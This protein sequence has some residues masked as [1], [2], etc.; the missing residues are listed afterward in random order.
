MR[1][2]REAIASHN[3]VQSAPFA[4]S[5][6]LVPQPHQPEP[7]TPPETDRIVTEIEV[8]TLARVSLATVRRWR[9][10]RQGPPYRKVGSLVRYHQAEVQQWL[11]DLPRR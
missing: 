5:H 8:A 11:E 2:L 6:V 7:K 1:L 10:L 4:A 9:L 3:V